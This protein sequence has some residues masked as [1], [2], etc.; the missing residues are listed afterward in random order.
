M[1]VHLVKA[2]KPKLGR[3]LK[4]TTP[5]KR[6]NITFPA[7]L[8]QDVQRY[9]S[10]GDVHTSIAEFMQAAATAYLVKRAAPK[11]KR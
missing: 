5:P 2:T 9:I 6:L 10:A 11:T 7:G 8:Y 3:P 4:Y 1:K